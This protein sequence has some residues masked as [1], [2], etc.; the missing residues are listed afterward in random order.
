MSKDY[1]KILAAKTDKENLAKLT[2]LDNPAIIEFIGEY[3]KLCNPKS[4]FV[5][6]D[7]QTDITYIKEKALSLGEENSLDTKGHTYHFDGHLDQARDKKNTRYLI[8]KDSKISYYVNS[9]ERNQGLAEIKDI[10]K[11]I[12]KGKEMFVCFFC[13]GPV[14]SAFSILAVQITDSSYVAH[15]EDILYRPG[16]EQFKKNKEGKDFFRFVHSAGELKAAVSK[17]F[18]KRRV[19]IYLENNLV[20]STN[21]QYAGNTVGLKKLSLR[22]AIQKASREGW[23]AEHMFL[24]GVSDE[25]GK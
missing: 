8:P 24:M 3:V 10:L 25:S 18:D 21:T 5:R 4:I 9:I 6:T 1:L 13:L 12:M 23:L 2:C 11:D 17:N 7:L 19:Y 16:Y 22:L 15:S 20:Y 14:D